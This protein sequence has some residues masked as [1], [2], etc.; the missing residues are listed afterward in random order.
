[1]VKLPVDTAHVGCVTVLKVGTAGVNGCALITALL[2]VTDVHPTE[3]VTV[4][5]YVP[6]AIPLIVVVV[7]VPVVVTPPG[8]LVTVHVPDEGKPLNATLPVAKTHVGCVI[9]PTTGA[10]AV[11][12]CAL[13]VTLDDDADVHAPNVAVTV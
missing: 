4:K 5:V 13:T 6:A 1:M 3:F 8:I 7:P 10:L 9:V 2:D 11:A 12:G